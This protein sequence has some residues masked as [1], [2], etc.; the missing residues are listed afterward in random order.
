MEKE[1][2]NYPMLDL[3]V[4]PGFCVRGNRIVKV[5][6]AAG[7]LQ[8][9]PGE[10]VRP[11]LRT[12]AAEYAT[13]QGGC[14]YLR[15]AVGQ[16]DF[17]AAVSRVEGADVFVLDSALG[18]S[19]LRA[20]AL[21][22][23]ELRLPLQGAILAAKSLP[24]PEDPAAQEQSARLSRGL[25]Q[26]LRIVGNMSDAGQ[27]SPP[28]RQEIREIGSVFREIFEKA[29]TLV[30]HTGIRLTYQ[31]LREPVYSLA[32]QA[33][34]E[35]GVLNILSNAIRFT[36]SGGTIDA[37]LTRRREM[38]QL[39]IQDSGSGIPQDLLGGAFTRYQRHPGIEDGR[40][41]IGLGMLLV[42][43][44]ATSHG[45]AVLIDQPGKTGTRITLTMAI[46]QNTE[47]FL[48]SPIAQVDYA[49]E[50]DRMLVELSQCLPLE[51]YRDTL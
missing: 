20:M 45:G 41:G 51:L 23:Q 1:I 44:A 30:A 19:G 43:T 31:G 22:A 2:E 36:P 4:Q 14:L 21:A 28:S 38:L 29:E 42:R 24:T 40:Y 7:Q 12:G 16:E 11:R 25:H 50:F 35:R 27:T 13:F 39:C 46:R 47:P 3:L 34:L 33:L 37:S 18:D 49:G 15:L 5:N 48:R 17:G 8:L 26:L 9:T 10:D 32:D 6:Q